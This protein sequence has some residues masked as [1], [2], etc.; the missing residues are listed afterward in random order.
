MGLVHG[1]VDVLQRIR[2]SDKVAWL[3]GL[4][5]SDSVFIDQEELFGGDGGEGGISGTF[6]FA[7]GDPL[8][9]PSSYLQGNLGTPL[10]AFRG[11]TC[12][13]LET[14]YISSN[15]PYLKPWSFI[16]TRTDVTTR[17]EEQWYVAKA[18]IPAVYDFEVT[19]NPGG[20]I[21]PTSEP[22]LGYV[23]TGIPCGG[24]TDGN[25]VGDGDFRVY[26]DGA[27]NDSTVPDEWQ[28]V[29]N[30]YRVSGVF[31]ALAVQLCGQSSP[32]KVAA[33]RP[34]SSEN[35]E[36]IACP[37]GSTA[38]ISFDS[39]SI[40]LAKCYIIP[41][42]PPPPEPPETVT[43]CAHKCLDM[44][45]AHIIRECL[46]DKEWGMGY[47]DADIDD[48]AFTAAAD[49]LFAEEMGISLLW[50]RENTIEAFVQDIVR[51]IDAALYV[52][53]RTGRF[54]LKL[55]RDDYSE[56][57]LITLGPN[58]IERV[59]NY[60]RPAFGDL[61]NSVTVV[62]DECQDGKFLELRE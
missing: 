12:G 20:A 44:N 3:G 15:N 60:K 31:S 37:L 48:V 56:S 17:G 39:G 26:Y 18:R 11:V 47:A 22:E 10:P 32:N 13:I 16:L 14:M 57:D 38:V 4:E 6:T 19:C 5:E 24:G 58:E 7:N 29:T 33:R 34:Y 25:I 40:N 23:D 62:Y 2:V 21:E 55:I 50:Q 45:P 51:H 8:Q 41:E 36:G 43:T 59:E 61:V 1:P 30:D 53:R 35:G 46:T 28:L 42:E 27:L 9:L 54:V 52:D 49:T